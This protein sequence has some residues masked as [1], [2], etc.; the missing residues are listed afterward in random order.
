METDIHDHPREVKLTFWLL[1][2]LIVVAAIMLLG[3]TV[4]HSDGTSALFG[5]SNPPRSMQKR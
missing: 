1:C 3:K 5:N 4:T 2:T